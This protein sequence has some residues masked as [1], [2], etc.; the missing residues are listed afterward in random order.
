M[1][2]GLM[3]HRVTIQSNTPVQNSTGE[4]IDSWADAATVWAEVRPLSGQEYIQARQ[5]GA[6]V[7]TR[8]RMRRRA[9]TV[10]QRLTW[11][12]SESVAHIYD[13]DAVLPDRTDQ[14]TMI[15]M[16]SEGVG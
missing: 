2:A 13:I 10:N 14:R 12:D 4:E 6:N 9:L 8:I 3:R 11:T 15:V 16:C 7:T 1:Q 5:Q